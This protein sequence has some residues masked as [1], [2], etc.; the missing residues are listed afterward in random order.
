MRNEARLISLPP[1]S[2][3]RV[4]CFDKGQPKINTSSFRQ[5]ITE[6]GCR[7]ELINGVERFR[8]SDLLNCIQTSKRATRWS[9]SLTCSDMR[10]MTISGRADPSRLF[11]SDAFRAARW[12]VTSGRAGLSCSPPVQMKGMSLL[13]HT[14]SSNVSENTADKIERHSTRCS[15]QYQDVK[16]L[17]E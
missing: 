2:P 11:P 14:L 15:C 7:K 17:P 8:G 1:L 4:L 10:Q 16:V 9:V 6:S 13:T 5:I 12:S 3:R